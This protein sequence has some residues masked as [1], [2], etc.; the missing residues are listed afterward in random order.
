[1]QGTARQEQ[2]IPQGNP[3]GAGS[4]ALR[5]SAIDQAMHGRFRAALALTD[6]GRKALHERI[7]GLSASAI[8]G[9]RPGIDGADP[10]WSV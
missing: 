4:N 3:P 6:L 1:M 8:G 2:R 7:P 10:G 5:T 9:R